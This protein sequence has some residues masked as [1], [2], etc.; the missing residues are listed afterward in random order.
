MVDEASLERLASLGVTV[1][2]QPGI[3]AR[4]AAHFLAE[5]DPVD[6]SSLWRLQSL[7]AAGIPIALSSDAP[8]ADV[9]PWATI[10]AAISPRASTGVS[11][12]ISAADA[13]STL[14]TDPLDPGGRVREV[15]IGA[16]ADL[17][18]LRSSYAVALTQLGEIQV[19]ATIIAGELV[20]D[21]DAK[22]A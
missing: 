20:F 10:Q 19:R 8:Y 21:A 16:P 17:C 7:Q 5:T 12:A 14:L 18:L 6:H 3:F 2:T 11:E 22:L 1:V 9:D 4:N 15:A 13:L